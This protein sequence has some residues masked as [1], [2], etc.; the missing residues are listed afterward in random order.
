MDIRYS[1]DIVRYK[2]M[3]NSELR[4]VFAIETLFAPGCV[5]LTYSDIDRG[6]IGSA[7]PLGTVLELPADKELASD[8]FAQRREIGIINLGGQG[9]INVDGDTHVLGRLDCLYIGRESQGVKFASQDS[10]HPA[11]FYFVS[12]PAHTRYPTTL[13][14]KT[15]AIKKE[16]GT[17]EAANKR[18][19]FQCIHPDLVTTCQILLGFTV[20]QVGSVWNTFPPHTHT[21]R[22]EFYL[23]FDMVDDAR[24]FHMMGEEDYVR[25]M[26]LK[27][28]DVALS[29]IWS[30]HCGVG[31]GAYS[32]V[33]C[34]GGENQDF[35]DMDFINPTNI[36]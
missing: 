15:Q 30:M 13:I 21:R 35:D 16:L 14:K 17:Q 32:F 18:T 22:S 1:A 4:D 3:S 9:R 31:T 6:V 28:G 7:V 27:N 23:Y 8:Y 10:E 20:I 12:Y 19:L 33:W 25:T 11:H 36:R 29:P 5:A 26:V 24:V 34:M 2:T